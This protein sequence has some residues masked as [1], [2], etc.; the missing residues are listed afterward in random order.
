MKVLEMAISAT[1]MAILDSDIDDNVFVSY[2]DALL[3]G[4]LQDYVQAGIQS[5]TAN[6]GIQP[7]IEIFVQQKM[8]AANCAAGASG[9]V[10]GAR[11]SG[12][13]ELHQAVSLAAAGKESAEKDANKRRKV[14]TNLR[15]RRGGQIPMFSILRLR[16]SGLRVLDRKERSICLPIAVLIHL[17]IFC[18]MERSSRRRHY[19]FSNFLSLTK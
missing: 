18:E 5:R 6:D 14:M 1:M 8:D 16:T 12:R 11:S 10:M 19:L 7:P 17:E 9:A 4:P 2:E 13:R 15:F 3:Q